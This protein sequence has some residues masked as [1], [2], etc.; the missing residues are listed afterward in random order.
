MFQGRY[1]VMSVLMLLTLGCG[2]SDADP[3]HGPV[4]S[5]PSRGDAPVDQEAP[6]QAGRPSGTVTILTADGPV[7]FS[8]RDVDGLAVAEGDIVLGPI[9]DGRLG[10]GVEPNNDGSPVPRAL[11]TPLSTQLWPNG[12]IPFEVA[13]DLHAD[14]AV[15][16]AI[17]HYHAVTKLRFKPRT[18]E[19]N[20]IRFVN[21]LPLL[22]SMSKLGMQ[23]GGQ[24]IKLRTDAE[25]RTAIHEIGHALGL[26]H[27]HKRSDRDDF[28][29][30]DH[31]CIDFFYG[32][33]GQYTIETNARRVGGYD[34]S[35]IMHY[36]SVAGVKG[37][38][39]ARQACLTFVV[40]AT[41]AA[42]Q[43]NMTLSNGDISA[44]HQLYFPDLTKLK[45]LNPASALMVTNNK[46]GKCL[47][48]AREGMGNGAA[49]VQATCDGTAPQRWHLVYKGNNAQGAGL[50]QFMSAW[51]GK[52]IDIPSGETFNGVE[53]QQFSCHNGSNQLLTVQPGNY[54]NGATHR[55]HHSGKCVDVPG[56]SEANHTRIQQF[57]CHGAANQQ[58]RLR[59]PASLG[60]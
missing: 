46:S 30:I 12:V 59:T 23:T 21:Q 57:T 19:A 28:I 16:D 34:L 38:P 36:S 37:P 45:G 53:L 54:V 11:A 14:S 8:Y 48:V 25:T 7:E 31:D 55:F 58:W 35:S 24:E 6:P 3:L 1:G 42:L 13:P 17:A 9:E 5:A 40:R 18:G 43:P 41:G 4:R 27:E 47:Q 39:W 20:F 32:V 51:S 52:C 50:Y 10:T 56:G 15:E 22:A 44:L 26:L 60:F 29:Q 2:G 33:S 49:I